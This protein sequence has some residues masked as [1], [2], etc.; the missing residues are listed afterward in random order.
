MFDIIYNGQRRSIEDH[1]TVAQLLS[2]SGI[3]IQLC[4]VELNEEVLPRTS[5]NQHELQANDQ[6]EVVTFVGG[7]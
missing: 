2:Q 6:V 3:N 1:T 7:G 5:F 4:A